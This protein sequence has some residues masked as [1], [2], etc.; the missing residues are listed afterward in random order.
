MHGREVM[1]KK[2]FEVIE[3]IVL[4]AIFLVLV[5]TFIEDLAVI[6]GWSWNVRRVLILTGFG[7]DIFFTIE[8]LTRF[9]RALVRGNLREYMIGRRGWIDLLA[10]V[11]LLLLSSGPA[12]IAVI[13]GGGVIGGAAGIL[14]VLKVVKAVRIARVLRLLRVLKIFKQIKNTDSVMAQRHISKITTMAVSIFVAVLLFGSIFMQMLSLPSASKENERVVTD[15]MLMYEKSPSAAETSS[16]LLIVKRDGETVFTRFDNDYYSKNF[17]FNDYLYAEYL[18]YQFFFDTRDIEKIQSVDNIMFFIII[19]ALVLAYTL[20]YSPHFA[21]TVSDPIHVMRRGLEEK[22]YNF[23]VRIN[24][25]YAD[26][27]IFRLAENYNDVYLPLKDRSQ[28]EDE[29]DA[30]SLELKMDDIKNMF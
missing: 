20:F 18:D 10:S 19:L 2:N 4:A 25:E 8:F 16:M 6:A 21:I 9:Y 5:Q 7:F 22:S 27:D 11:T 3:N 26:D 23:E 15:L 29:P 14:N 17:G 1:S 13:L 12:A 24:P 30:D 28:A